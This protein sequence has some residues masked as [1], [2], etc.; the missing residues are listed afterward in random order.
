MGGRSPPPDVPPTEGIAVLRE[1]S[2][3]QVIR[4][5][6]P[7]VPEAALHADHHGTQGQ[8]GTVAGQGPEPL[9]HPLHRNRSGVDLLGPRV[10]Q[11]GRSP[12]QPVRYVTPPSQP[13]SAPLPIPAAPLTRL[14]ASGRAGRPENRSP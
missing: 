9:H 6:T 1:R 12:P 14:G 11:V 3:A 7:P 5:R 8:Q 4:A 10:G 2:L 13:G